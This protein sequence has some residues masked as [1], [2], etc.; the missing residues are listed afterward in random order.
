MAVIPALGGRGCKKAS[1]FKASLSFHE[2]EDSL[3]LY[4]ILSQ[5][6]KNKNR[7]KIKIQ[8][9]IREAMTYLEYTSKLLELTYLLV[10]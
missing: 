4:E 9:K 6:I 1:E 10:P 7:N 5:K 2:L 8:T 3:G